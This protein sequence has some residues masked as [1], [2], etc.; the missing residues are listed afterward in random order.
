MTL[1]EGTPYSSAI[2]E[3]STR[4]TGPLPEQRSY[5][6]RALDLSPG[7]YF[8]THR[9]ARPNGGVQT[10]NYELRVTSQLRH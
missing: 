2:I 3:G 1:P 10:E 9:R 6:H 5:T 7:V 8:V 4:A